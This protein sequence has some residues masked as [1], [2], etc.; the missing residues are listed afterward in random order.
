MFLNISF[1]IIDNNPWQTRT[2]ANEEYIE[3]LAADI[4]KNG[5]LQT[6]LARVILDG[7]PVEPRLVHNPAAR[8]ELAFGHNRKQAMK[9]NGAKAMPLDLRELSD[10]Q[11]AIYAW[12]ENEKRLEL[13]PLEKAR[14]IQ[15]LIESFGWTHA[16]TGDYLGMSRSSVSN[17]VRLL[18]LP[19]ALQAD[20]RVTN[21]SA[22]SAEALLS[23]LAVPDEILQEVRSRQYLESPENIIELAME[24]TKS[25]EDVR[26][27]TGYLIRQVC[28][29]L[30][31]ALFPLEHIFST[32]D[33]RSPK[34]VDC[35]HKYDRGAKSFCVHGACAR[36]KEDA[37]LQIE[38][39]RTSEET[40]IPVVGEGELDNG[41]TSFFHQ[42]KHTEGEGGILESGCPNLRLRKDK[43]AGKGERISDQYPHVAVVCVDRNCQCLQ[44]RRHTAQTEKQQAVEMELKNDSKY[45]ERRARYRVLQ[46]EIIDP[47]VKALRHMFDTSLSDIAFWLVITKYY[48]CSSY[49]PQP[50]TLEE[51]WDELAEMIVKTKLPYRPAD[52]SRLC[53]LSND[54]LEA[55]R[56]L[57]LDLLKE[58][59]GEQ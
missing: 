55:A 23:L 37:W 40:G 16:K 15:N 13:H 21:L 27:N 14:A 17:A 10:Q 46:E 52:D 49:F 31:D 45:Q 1:N 19:A 6:P 44:D 38:L 12:S 18:S 8:V 50:D 35:E 58:A 47:A 41:Y 22:R 4:K 5:L 3:E 43:F 30:S 59:R 57:I 34:C 2:V 7:K 54:W 42:H 53:Y 28:V 48:S 29:E 9:R 11:M 20:E 51:L 56:E 39:E 24:G 32:V 25:S 33:V 26:K 36:T